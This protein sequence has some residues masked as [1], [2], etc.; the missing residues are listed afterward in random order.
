MN[1]PADH[2]RTRGPVMT[3]STDLHAL[4]EVDLLEHYVK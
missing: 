4:V 1:V 2:V 3:M